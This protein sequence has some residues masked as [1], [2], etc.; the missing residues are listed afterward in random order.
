M[1][2]VADQLGAEDARAVAALDADER[3][4]L[5]L[6]LGR[7]DRRLFAEANGLSE[8]EAAERLRAANQRGRRECSFLRFTASR[9]P[10]R[11]PARPRR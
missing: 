8:A 11:S 9:V 7:R 4:R 3:L 5:A 6:E 10:C 2:R 1:K